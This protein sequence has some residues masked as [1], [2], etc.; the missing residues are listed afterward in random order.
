VAEDPAEYR[1][2]LV[3]DE[4][5]ALVPALPAIALEGARAVGKTAS[6]LRRAQ[7]VFRLEDAQQRAVALA[8]PSRIVAAPRPVLID[9]WQRAPEAW[10]HVRRAVDDGAAAGSFLLTGS[11]SGTPPPAHTG[12]GRIV[13]VRMRPMSLAERGVGTPTVSLRELL[14]GHRP[15]LAGGTPVG[16]ADYAHEIVASGLPGVRELPGRALRSQLDGY[17]D[18][19]LDHDVQQS[20]GRRVRRPAS[21]R[22]WLAAYAAATS[23][24]A[25]YET[26]RDAATGGVAEK[27]AKSTTI[28]YRDA[29]HQLWILDPVPAWVPWRNRIARLSQPPKH[30]LMDPALAARL[31]GVGADG[32]LDPAAGDRG[33]RDGPL[34]GALFE[35]LVA[36]DLRVCAQAAEARLGHLRTAR[37]EREVDFIVERGDGRVVAL[38]VKL[39][40]APSDSDVRHLRWLRDT[41]GDDLLDAA[42]ITTGQEAYRRRDGIGVIPAALLGP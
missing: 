34:L 22:A 20:A 35:S 31:L 14:S 11:A 3:D 2:R 6:G 40:R 41:I 17:L 5:D 7:T 10:D 42:V 39:G 23:S 8:D 27:P 12:A 38:E 29:L 13:S 18:R 9:E 21:L 16:L 32:L 25:S 33:M 24:T 19:L 1:R 28:P 4:L 30:H 36:L 26:I 15:Q 37:G